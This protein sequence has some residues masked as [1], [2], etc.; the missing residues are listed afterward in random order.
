MLGATTGSLDGTLHNTSNGSV[1]FA[2]NDNQ[3]HYLFAPDLSPSLFTAGV[4]VRPAR[5]PARRRLKQNRRHHDRRTTTETSARSTRGQGATPGQ[6][7]NV[8]ISG[9][10]FQ[11]GATSSFGAGTTKFVTQTSFNSPT[12]LT[13]TIAMTANATLGARNLTVSN[14]DG[15][16]ATL[17]A[18]FTIEAPPPTPQS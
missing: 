4:P 1:N 18:A 14:P 12:S 5:R 8:T 2:T 16:N 3:T 13:A 11:T 7:L 10:N 6:T 15:G 17:T 9:S